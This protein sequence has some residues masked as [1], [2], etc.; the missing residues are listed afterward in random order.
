ME[1]LG[2]STDGA[3]NRVWQHWRLDSAWLAVEIGANG[4]VHAQISA[5]HPN[6]TLSVTAPPSATEEIGLLQQVMSQL[7]PED[8]LFAELM[9]AMWLSL[10]HD[11]E[12]IDLRQAKKMA[13]N[14]LPFPPSSR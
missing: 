1:W 7:P 8:P 14:V 2:T 9:Q 11:V 13:A 10:Q 3:T 5:E 6:V 12:L 4:C